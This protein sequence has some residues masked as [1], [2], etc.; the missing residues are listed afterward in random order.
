MGDSESQDFKWESK[1]IGAVEREKK[2]R[3]KKK[4]HKQMFRKWLWW[5]KNRIL[6]GIL[7]EKVEL[8]AMNIQKQ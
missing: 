4:S 5:K 6:G 3:K 1:Y 2:R 8:I 7:Q